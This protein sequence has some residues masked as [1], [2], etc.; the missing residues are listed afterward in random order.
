MDKK[1]KAAHFDVIKENNK[2]LI[3]NLVR[4]YG[5]ISYILIFGHLGFPVRDYSNLYH[6]IS[7]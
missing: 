7:R 3:R 2:R 1:D 4:K 5:A 6:P